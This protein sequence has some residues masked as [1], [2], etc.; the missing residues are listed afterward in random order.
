MAGHDPDYH[1]CRFE[2]GARM[3][4]VQ[5]PLIHR[6]SLREKVFDVLKRWILEGTLK[7]GQKI[8]EATLASRLQVSRAPLR[9]ALFLLAQQGLVTI[10]PHRGT[11]VTRLSE[12]EIREI[13][14]LREILETH[15]AKRLRA[16]LTPE[17]A[18]ELKI[19]LDRLR[20]ATRDRNIVAFNEADFAFHRTL[21]TLSGNQNMA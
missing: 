13:F 15:A 10:R 18:E 3:S 7:P 5:E 19:A 17:K 2:R 6:E 21:W 9:E 16:N 4:L 12:C 11:Y 14:E 1:S 8:I 20:K